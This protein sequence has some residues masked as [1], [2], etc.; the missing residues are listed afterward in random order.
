M[1]THLDEL[2]A[3]IQPARKVLISHPLYNEMKTLSHLQTFMSQHVFAVWDF[4]SLLKSL[5]RQLTCT[6]L[7]W[8][9]VGTPSTR[10]FIN[11]IVT[12]EE[13]DLDENGLRKSHFEL[14]LSSMAQMGSDASAI[15]QLLGLL[16][17]GKTIHEALDSVS[18]PDSVR[19][20]VNYTFDVIETQPI[21][22]QAA[23]FT[24]G[25][26]DLIPDMFINIVRELAIE[27]PE[28]LPIF[29]YYLE[30]H[31]EVD[32][33]EHSILGKQMVEELCGDDTQKWAEATAASIKGLE[34]RNALWN[35]ILKSF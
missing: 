21:H 24:F 6:T 7:P 10:Y 29:K 17:E 34:M 12:G 1:S 31:I 23:V 19:D 9:P 26:E 18:V 16:K 3:A 25:R 32:G 20:F 35:G 4:M 11:E 8:I 14:Y 30:R 22:V 5:Q 27:Y 13:C 28:K 15:H 2:V 33:D